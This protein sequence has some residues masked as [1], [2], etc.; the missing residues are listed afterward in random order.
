MMTKTWSAICHAIANEKSD[1]DNKHVLDAEVVSKLVTL[2]NTSKGWSFTFTSG[3]AARGFTFTSGRAA[4]GHASFDGRAARGHASFDARLA[5]RRAR[6]FGMRR[7]L[8]QHEYPR[9][10]KP[11]TQKHRHAQT[12]TDL[13]T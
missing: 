8:A 12:G 6:V 13:Q 11:R 4:R 2:G 3:R 10:Q 1:E 5:L 9:A 7:H